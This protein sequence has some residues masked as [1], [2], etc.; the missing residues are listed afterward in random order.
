MKS[1]TWIDKILYQQDKHP[2]VEKP[3]GATDT[4][5][6]VSVHLE[7]DLFS[8]ECGLVFISPKDKKKPL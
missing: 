4:D 5:Q 7:N 8:K 2:F 6:E 1:R 3:D